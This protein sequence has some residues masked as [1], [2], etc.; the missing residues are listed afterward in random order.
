MPGK[1]KQLRGAVQAVKAAHSARVA[2]K[3]SVRLPTDSQ[4]HF[5]RSKRRE[6]ALRK[7]N[8]PK[9]GDWE[10]SHEKLNLAEHMAHASA[11]EGEWQ[12]LYL[13]FHGEKD[14]QKRQEL[15]SKMRACA[16][17]W[18]EH[19]LHH[20]RALIANSL[21][22]KRL[23]Q[24]NRET[25]QRVRKALSEALAGGVLLPTPLDLFLTRA[26]YER[27]STP[28]G[29]R[30]MLDTEP[31]G[32]RTTLYECGRLRAI[33]GGDG[34]GLEA[35]IGPNRREGMTYLLLQH[36]P[37]SYPGGM[38]RQCGEPPEACT[39]H[40]D[41]L[42]LLAGF[43]SEAE[44]RVFASTCYFREEQCGP[45]FPVPLSGLGSW[46]ATTGRRMLQA[47]GRTD[48]ILNE[49]ALR[50]MKSRFTNGADGG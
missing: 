36:L 20:G 7:G 4:R 44:A 23:A 22:R 17:H 3:A 30:I 24:E 12:E 32:E 35:H 16:K 37:N 13:Q 6:L 21:E 46:L 38:C 10:H 5:A 29:L 14:P 48:Q 33:G 1:T 31:F 11:H 39:H 15:L 19:R 2:E 18:H 41:R 45:L 27:E 26:G 9:P 42:I 47:G 25:P 50:V 8:R 43:S 28:D 49:A 40:P 34:F